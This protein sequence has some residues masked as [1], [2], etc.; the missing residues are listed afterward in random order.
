MSQP[1]NI[2]LR[3][4]GLEADAD[5]KDALKRVSYQPGMLLG[6]EATRDEQEYH[7]RHLNRHGYWLHGY[8]TVVGLR[9]GI[10]ADNPAT[11]I[12]PTRVRLLVSPGIGVD[13]LGR[14]VT[15]SEP[16]CIDLGAWLTSQYEDTENNSWNALISDGYDTGTNKLWL[17]VT[18]RYQENASGLQP[19]LGVDVNAGSDPVQPSRL[20][21]SVLFE[22][23]AERPADAASAG[24]PFAAHNS[25]PEWNDE[26][27]GKLSPGEQA[28]IESSS[29]ATQQQLRLAARLL[30]AVANDNEALTRRQLFTTTAADIARTLLARISVRLTTERELIINPHRITVDNLAR[31]FLL[32]A[33]TLAELIRT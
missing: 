12:E 18:M 20:K 22:L 28:Q 27:A 31:P 14:E 4:A 33:A 5:F 7:R 11:D 24:R 10:K 25:L 13:G 19:V 29:G 15:V 23:V 6:L 17:A 8:G 30:H 3:D 9:V 21:D 1:D 2:L 26:L 16:Y 32:N